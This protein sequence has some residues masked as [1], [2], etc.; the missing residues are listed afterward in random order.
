MSASCP[1][2]PAAVGAQ[3]SCF[4]HQPEAR[5]GQ[6]WRQAHAHG[7]VQRRGWG[8]G[9]QIADLH[10]EFVGLVHEHPLLVVHGVLVRQGR[11][12]RRDGYRLRDGI[13]LDGNELRRDGKRLQLLQELQQPLGL[14]RG[15]AEPIGRPDAPDAVAPAHVLQ[16][17]LADAVTVADGNTRVVSLAAAFDGREKD[18]AVRRVPDAHFGPKARHAQLRLDLVALVA[19]HV[20]HRRSELGLR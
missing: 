20:H 6:A 1:G 7:L 8:V 3:R 11:Q 17:L 10:L 9:H 2:S 14:G 18:R 5:V 19:Q 15:N 4:S 12:R 16:D 13:R